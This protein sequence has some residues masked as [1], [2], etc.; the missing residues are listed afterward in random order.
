MAGPSFTWTIAE[1]FQHRFSAAQLTA[2]AAAPA[3]PPDIEIFR[4]R[5]YRS[6]ASRLENIWLVSRVLQARGIAIS[7]P[8]AL[9]ISRQFG[10]RRKACLAVESIPDSLPLKDYIDGFGPRPPGLRLPEGR[11]LIDLFMEFSSRLRTACLLPPDFNLADVLICA[12][13]DGSPSLYLRDAGRLSLKRPAAGSLDSR[14]LLAAALWG[15]APSQPELFFLGQYFRSISRWG[16]T[17]CLVCADALKELRLFSPWPDSSFGRGYLK[18]CVQPGPHEKALLQLLQ[19]PQSLFVRPDAVMLK[20]SPTTTAMLLPVPDLPFPL[21]VKRYNPKGR[22]FGLKYLLRQS[23]A[24]RVWS[25][26]RKL[27]ERNFPTPEV[28]GFVEQ[29]RFGFLQAAYLV[30]RG[31]ARA[32]SLDAYIEKH[33]A[34]WDMEKKNRF[35]RQVAA[36]VR[37]AHDQGLVHGDLKA[38]NILVMSDGA[39]EQLRLIDLDAARLHK[40][41][42]LMACCRDMARLNC[43]FLSRALIS[44]SRRLC[45]LKAYLQEQQPSL[46]QAWQVTRELSLRKLHRSGRSFSA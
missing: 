33:V 7:R 30:T 4:S 20:N 6:Q 37:A 23:R 8:I 31:L 41:P 13:A 42:D 21:Y 29:R 36:L 18:G 17:A 26:S 11:N 44:R 34:K 3:A 12:M 46:R 15:K 28:L 43:S 2:L 14:R 16:R 45:F 9:G 22:F 27:Q 39:E 32:E 24:R 40:R 10:G 35:T 1:E 5:G 19:H 25:L 38:T